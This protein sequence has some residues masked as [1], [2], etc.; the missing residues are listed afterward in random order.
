MQSSSLNHK[1]KQSMPEKIGRMAWWQARWL[2]K[3]LRDPTQSNFSNVTMVQVSNL[4]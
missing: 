2:I 1:K 3:P 4:T